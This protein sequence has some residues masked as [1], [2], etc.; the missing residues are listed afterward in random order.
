MASRR[1]PQ[2]SRRNRHVSTDQSA[3]SAGPECHKSA[4][5]VFGNANVAIDEARLLGRLC[6]LPSCLKRTRYDREMAI[7]W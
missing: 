7:T 4:L 1:E 3:R 6:A 5:K 2:E